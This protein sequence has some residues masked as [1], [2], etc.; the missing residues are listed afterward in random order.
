MGYGAG[1]RSEAKS[2]RDELPTARPWER[3][4]VVMW[5]DKASPEAGQ[6]LGLGCAVSSQPN[7]APFPAIPCGFSPAAQPRVRE[8]TAG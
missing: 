4:D 2:R 1:Y 6:G 7:P 3:Q 5:G 8:S